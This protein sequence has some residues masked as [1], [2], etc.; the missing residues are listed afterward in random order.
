MDIRI[1]V[2]RPKAN[3]VLDSIIFTIYTTSISRQRRHGNTT[4]GVGNETTQKS[5]QVCV[6]QRIGIIVCEFINAIPFN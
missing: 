3:S 1:E 2:T 5:E 4:R 6:V